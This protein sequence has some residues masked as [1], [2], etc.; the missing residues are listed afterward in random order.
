MIFQGKRMSRKKFYD[1]MDDALP[2]VRESMF[3]KYIRKFKKECEANSLK[4]ITQSEICFC[5]VDYV[6]EIPV[7]RTF[8]YFYNITNKTSSFYECKREFLGTCESLTRGR[9]Y[10]YYRYKFYFDGYKCN[11]SNSRATS[12]GYPVQDC[13]GYDDVV[14]RYD[15]YG[16]EAIE[17]SKLRANLKLEAYR[18]LVE[19][20]RY[21]IAYK[22][23]CFYKIP[24]IDSLTNKQLAFVA[25][26]QFNEDVETVLAL[27]VYDVE[28][29]SAISYLTNEMFDKIL[30]ETGMTKFNFINFAKRYYASRKN[31]RNDIFE[32]EYRFDATE[33]LDYLKDLKT[34]EIPLN[35]DLIYNKKYREEHLAMQEQIK[36]K[37]TEEMNKKYIEFVPSLKWMEVQGEYTIKVPS[38]IAEFKEEAT[39]Q[40]NC[41]YNSKYYEKVVNGESIILFVRTNE[42][43]N[44]PY[45]TVELKAKD[46]KINQCKAIKNSE[47]PKS[48]KDFV[49]RM[50]ERYKE[51]QLCN[52]KNLLNADMTGHKQLALR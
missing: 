20:P 22:L 27:G 7:V 1:L 11:W 40:H 35:H 13:F 24:H 10:T 50:V 4:K 16:K 12:C 51:V 15:F 29:V 30:K 14:F 49:K 38:T 5:V 41:L 52:M 44:T 45:V 2:Q 26:N 18:R 42:K 48:V 34:L 3:S 43:P 6:L 39:Y 36:I 21:E 47:P 28:A 31:T 33:Y 19:E 46:F 32:K 23:N 9:H 37:I 25:K 17:K 8:I